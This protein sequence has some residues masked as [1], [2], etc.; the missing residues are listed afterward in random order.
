MISTQTPFAIASLLLIGTVGVLP[1]QVAPESVAQALAYRRLGDELAATTDSTRAI[2]ALEAMAAAFPRDGRTW[3]SLGRRRAAAGQSEAAVDAL[4]R[5]MA[6][7][8]LGSAEG[9]CL[10]ARTLAP[11]HPGAAAIALRRCLE[12]GYRF[13]DAARHG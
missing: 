5:A 10:V 11:R 3:L 12:R 4:R 8:E 13:R 7:G 9:E 1:A 2:R 6:L